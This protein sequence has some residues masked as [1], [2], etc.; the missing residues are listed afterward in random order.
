MRTTRFGFLPRQFYVAQ[1]FIHVFRSGSIVDCRIIQDDRMVRHRVVQW[2][3]C[4]GG[5]SSSAERG[6]GEGMHDGYGGLRIDYDRD[7]EAALSALVREENG[8]S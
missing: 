3:G 4:E 8:T 5:M 6:M 2:S 1:S 7:T